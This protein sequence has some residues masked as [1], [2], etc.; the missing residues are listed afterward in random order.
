MTGD[1]FIDIAGKI[2]ATY[3]EPA[4][5]R[6]AV[7][8][9]Y[10]GAFHLAKAFLAEI[11]VRPP[12]NANTHVFI[13]QRLCNCG[14]ADG[15]SVGALLWD[16]YAARLKADYDLGDA[17]VETVPH[18]R[19]CVETARALQSALASCQSDASRATI[20]AGI[21]DYEKRIAGG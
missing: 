4:S 15:Q 14:H 11:G 12:K 16:L 6:T 8:R 5:C 19:T 3:S 17:H 9:A 1:Q 2:A 10:Y 7:G 18:A 20:K 21:D 13:R